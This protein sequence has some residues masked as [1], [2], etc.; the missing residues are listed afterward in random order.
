MAGFLLCLRVGVQ[1]SQASPPR[2]PQAGAVEEAPARTP[3]LAL[4]VES[5]RTR[6]SPSA[7]RED[8]P[9]GAR[10]SPPL[11]VLPHACPGHRADLSPVSSR[12][13]GH[14]HAPP[15]TA[16]SGGSLS[17]LLPGVIKK[18]ENSAPERCHSRTRTWTVIWDPARA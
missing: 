10:D 12:E 14:A 6:V 3:R 16:V 8:Q 11:C 5:R 1:G 13:S 7:R 4:Q 18:W 17:A 15:S 9:E 2:S